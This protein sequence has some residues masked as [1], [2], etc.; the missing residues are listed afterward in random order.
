MIQL[1]K[2]K[3][4]LPEDTIKEYFVDKNG[5]ICGYVATHHLEYCN[6]FY[7]LFDSESRIIKRIYY[8]YNKET[9]LNKNSIS[10][11]DIKNFITQDFKYLNKNII[12]TEKT[13]FYTKK[14]AS[15]ILFHNNKVF[16]I[17][18]LYNEL[19]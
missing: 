9:N 12:M 19:K 4:I 8:S 14:P 10:V 15:K 2:I 7:E 18:V 5:N 13:Y 11:F 1:N 16:G 6:V 17:S 3:E